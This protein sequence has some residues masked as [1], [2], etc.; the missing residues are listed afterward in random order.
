MH[1]VILSSIFYVLQNTS[2]NL[3]SHHF[4]RGLFQLSLLNGI[5]LLIGSGA[6]LVLSH[7]GMISLSA[8]LLATVYGALFLLT[9][10]LIAVTLSMGPLSMSS[11]IINMSAVISII[12]GALLFEET[13]TPACIAAFVLIGIA[14]VMISIP[15]Q[16]EPLRA[17]RGWLPIAL[18]TMVFNG[19][20]GVV[21]KSA[22]ARDPNLGATDFTFWSM[23]CGAGF[24]MLLLAIVSLMGRRFAEGEGLKKLLPL[25]AGIGIGTAGGLGFQNNALMLLPSLVVYPVVV[26]LV[27]TLLQFVSVVLFH[28]RLTPRR[29]VAI[30]IGLAGILLTNF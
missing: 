3:F 20:L 11:L 14:L 29:I 4:R 5:G 27:V 1:L 17:K 30:L 25:S 10:S 15:E 21:A 23:L 2:N 7:P 18:V 9:S 12:A 24:C 26:G 19:L 8:M 22:L 28:E 16:K 6:L 13:I